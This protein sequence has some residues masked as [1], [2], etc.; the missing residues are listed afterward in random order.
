MTNKGKQAILAGR[1]DFQSPALIF[2][3]A[4][5][6]ADRLELS[7]WHFGGRYNRRVPLKNVLQVDVVNASGLVIWLSVGETLRIRIGGALLWKQEID[8][9]LLSLEGCESN[10]RLIRNLKP[11]PDEVEALDQEEERL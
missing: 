6:Y 7:G 3:K 9:R 1:F 4:R 8:T 5:L 11:D 2:P 10:H